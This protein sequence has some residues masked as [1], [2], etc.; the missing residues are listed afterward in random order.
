MRGLASADVLAAGRRFADALQVL[1]GLPT[2]ILVQFMYVH[3]THELGEP[4]R[5]HSLLVVHSHVD[6]PNSY[7][8]AVRMALF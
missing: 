6:G 3:V 2:Y 5:E 8:Q 7:L 4:H 1:L